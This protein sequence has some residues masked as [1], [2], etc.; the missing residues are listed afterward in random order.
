[1]SIFESRQAKQISAFRKRSALA[2]AEQPAD[3]VLVHAIVNAPRS[4]RVRLRTGRLTRQRGQSFVEVAFGLPVL[5]ILLVGIIEIGRFAFYSVV[6]AGAARAGAQYGAQ[7][8]A[9][10]ADAAGIIHAAQNDGT[11]AG[12]TPNVDPPLQKC[13]CGPGTTLTSCAGGGLC[14]NPAVYVDVTAWEDV[15][16]LFALRIHGVPNPIRLSST[17]EMQ[18]GR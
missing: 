9:T 13:R 4:G 18:V 1:M 15:H 6:I 2:P 17:V 3:G 8:L 11:V 12:V 5:L 7:N 16:P 10:A 14:A